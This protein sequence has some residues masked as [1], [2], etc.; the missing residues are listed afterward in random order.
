MIKYI[1]IVAYE[2]SLMSS[3]VC[4]QSREENIPNNKNNHFQKPNNLKK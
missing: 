2:T 1:E 3:T 4:Q